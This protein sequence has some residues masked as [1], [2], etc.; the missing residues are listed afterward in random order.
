MACSRFS[1]SFTS[2]LEVKVTLIQIHLL[3]TLAGDQLNNSIWLAG[4]A[5]T[6]L[7]TQMEAVRVYLVFN[8]QLHTY[9]FVK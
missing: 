5:A 8:I 7:L 3:L 2:D 4:L 6:Y 9:N 1:E